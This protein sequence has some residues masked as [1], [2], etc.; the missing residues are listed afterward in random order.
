MLG[1]LTKT[2]LTAICLYVVV[3]AFGPADAVDSGGLASTDLERVNVG[4]P[5]PDFTLEDEKGNEIRL[6]QLRDQKNV[7]LVFY[8]GHW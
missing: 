6:S 4:S 2:A 5:A 3:L 1:S 8:R 7:L